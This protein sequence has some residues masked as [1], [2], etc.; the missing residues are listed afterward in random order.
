MESFIIFYKMNFEVDEYIYDDE[1]MILY[2]KNINDRQKSAIQELFPGNE[3]Y[4]SDMNFLKI[5]QKNQISME[6]RSIRAAGI[7][8]TFNCSLRCNY[9]SQSSCEGYS[10]EISKE[11]ITAFINEVIKKRIIT[12]IV[13]KERPSLNFTFTGGGEPTYN[14][15]LFQYTV[16]ELE[17]QCKKR[18]IDLILSMTTN[19]MLNN[20]KIEFIA[21]HFR[22]VMV[23]YDG[24]PDIQ[25]KNRKTAIDSNTSIEVSNTIKKLISSGVIVTIRTTLWQSDI[26]YMLDMYE[27]IGKEFPGIKIWDINPV[28]PAGRAEKVMKNNAALGNT[29]FLEEYLKLLKYKKMKPFSFRITSPIFSSEPVG[30][31]C[32]GV[33][34]SILEIW[35][36]P[37]KKITTCID[38]S[39]IV[40]QVGE[41]LDHKVVFYEKYKDPLLDMGIRKYEECRKCIAFRVCG[42]GCP[43]KHIRE[44]RAK[45]GMIHWEC[46]MEQRYWFLILRDLIS[47]KASME[48]KVD[49][50]R[51]LEKQGL[52]VLVLNYVN[53]GEEQNDI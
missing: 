13:L 48:W 38:S 43:L 40:T 46:R 11:D 7:V 23:S 9:C 1:R 10:E 14:W 35:L 24:T 47:K 36:L 32:G 12:A 18:N 20:K 21:S 6:K 26:K 34:P 19:G 41:V 3:K 29:D 52:D 39:E 51:A 42:S 28:T 22:K 50:S 27:Y 16:L 25:N 44:E 53:K 30:F 31:N 8:L 49:V 2:N 5:G 17:E 15:E 33:G 4:K 37:N 45:T